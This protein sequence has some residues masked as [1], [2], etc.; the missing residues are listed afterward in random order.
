MKNGFLN[1]LEFLFSAR[2]NVLNNVKSRL[3]Q[4]KHLDKISTCEPSPDLATEPTKN[5][6]S[7]LKLQQE[8]MN[9]NT[10]KKKIQMMKYFELILS[11]RIH[12]F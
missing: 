5:K 3:F 6:K 7:T 8:F 10:A 2:E 11:I 4:I 1:N 9:E 12:G